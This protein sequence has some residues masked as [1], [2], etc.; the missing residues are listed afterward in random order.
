MKGIFS[1]INLP[2]FV[3]TVIYLVVDKKFMIS[4]KIASRLPF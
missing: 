1:R 3:A 4:D 2:T